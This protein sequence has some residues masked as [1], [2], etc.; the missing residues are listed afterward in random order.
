MTS[1]RTLLNAADIKASKRLGQNFLT[2]A[3][4][5]RQIV[6]RAAVE[7][8]DQILEIGAGLGALTLH[9]ASTAYKVVAVEKDRRLLDLLR[10]ETLAAG[11][12][13]VELIGADFL[14]LDPSVFQA[15]AGRRLVVVG[16]LP[17]NIS[18]Q[19]I[20]RLVAHRQHVHHA[21]LMLQKEMALRLLAAPGGRDYGRLSVVLQYAARLER[22]LSVGAEHFFPRPKVDSVVITA[23]FQAPP[24]PAQDEVLL[25]QVVK[26][27]FA[28]RRKTLRN[29]LAGSFLNLDQ[30]LVDAWLAGVALD[31]RR[32][33]ETL[34]VAEFVRL[35]NWLAVQSHPVPTPGS[36]DIAGEAD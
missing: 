18:S 15:P 27:A 31:G 3:A 33:A 17:Y 30:G 34:S 23:H 2:N 10:T 20:V 9:L 4:I 12:T 26:A 8:H 1:P 6:A 25:S 36:R 24:E 22:A 21:A 19:I 14:T 28:Q 32:R 35:S 5:A 7:P 13:N 16:N 29:A 11:L